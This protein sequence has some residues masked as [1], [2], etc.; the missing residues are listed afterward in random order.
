MVTGL[1]VIKSYCI[2]ASHETKTNQLLKIRTYVI[3]VNKDAKK[4]EMTLT[5]NFFSLLQ[6]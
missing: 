4:L 1:I 6:S 5:L 2:Y 3:E